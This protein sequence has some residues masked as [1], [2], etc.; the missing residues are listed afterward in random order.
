[1]ISFLA[2]TPIRYRRAA[3]S[4]QGRTGIGLWRA[5]ATAPIVPKAEVG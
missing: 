1:M 5:A 4:P 2:R 3:G